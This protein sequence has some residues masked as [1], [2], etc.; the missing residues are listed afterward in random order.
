MQTRVRVGLA[1]VTALW[2]A[3]GCGGAGSR[4]IVVPRDVD[5]ASGSPRVARVIDMGDLGAVPAAGHSLPGLD[6]D[7]VFVV[8]ELVLIEGSNFGKQ[9]TVNI[10]GRPAR[11]IARTGNNAII[12]R[13]PAGVPT[14]ALEVEVSHES[15]RGAKEIT[16]RRYMLVVQD[17]SDLVHVVVIGK[18][19]RP[20]EHASLEVAG[21]RDVAISGDGVAAFVAIDGGTGKSAELGIIAMTAGGGPKLVRRQALSGGRAERVACATDAALGVVVG[22]TT[23]TAFD[24]GDARNPAIYAPW[25]LGDAAA[26][27]RALGIDPRGRFVA[28]LLADGNRLASI[29]MTTP[30][31]PRGGTTLDLLPAEHLSLV[32]DFG[33]SPNGDELWVIAGDNRESLVAGSHPARLIQVSTDGAAL[34][35]KREVVIAGASAPTVLA[36][37]RREAI[38][39]ATAIRSTSKRA[40][41]V[42]A[43]VEREFLEQV[44]KGGDLGAALAANPMN[45]GQLVS[46]DLEGRGEVIWSGEAVVLGAALSHD[47]RWLLTAA[48]HINRKGAAVTF[49]FGVT[50]N[51]LGG[52]KASYLRLAEVSSAGLLA[53][54]RIAIT[55]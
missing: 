4:V 53:P 7:G 35:H 9:P 19:G 30:A 28:L 13:I 43:G 3:V 36:V 29:D 22:G 37:A 5:A 55:P 44:N 40:A 15:G 8:G 26:S 54:A 23:M 42:A 25:N 31:A 39:G 2:G 34:A 49:E 38:M 11:T 47:V 12:S 17:G 24:L 46:T 1:L 32:A 6:S 27:L 41:I 14:G 51:A 10:G 45:S 33:F 16:L 21:A 52:D 48:T 50:S 18:D 20:A